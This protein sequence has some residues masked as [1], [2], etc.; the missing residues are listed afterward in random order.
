[1]VDRKPGEPRDKERDS[2]HPVD[3]L[4][5][6]AIPASFGVEQA[7][8]LMETDK[9]KWFICLATG[10]WLISSECDVESACFAVG[11]MVAA[12]LGKVNSVVCDQ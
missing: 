10:G 5:R 6:N 9:T 4:T 3:I 8:G 12:L 1:M 2:H 11:G 7:A